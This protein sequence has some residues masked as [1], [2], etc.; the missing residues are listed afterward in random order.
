LL[1]SI[2][3]TEA[4]STALIR[5]ASAFLMVTWSACWYT[6]ITANGLQRALAA[7]EIA[8]VCHRRADLHVVHNLSTNAVPA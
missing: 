5:F 8:K 4:S 6:V 7:T 3:L 2:G 1:L